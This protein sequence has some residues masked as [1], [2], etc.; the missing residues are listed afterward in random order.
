MQP[1]PFLEAIYQHYAAYKQANNGRPTPLRDL[2]DLV[3]T[4]PPPLCAIEKELKRMQATIRMNAAYF[5]AGVGDDKAPKWCEKV[6]DEAS[7]GDDKAANVGEKVED[8]AA[9]EDTEDDPYYVPNYFD[10]SEA[11]EEEEQAKKK[12]QIKLEHDTPLIYYTDPWDGLPLGYVWILPSSNE[13]MVQ[14]EGLVRDVQ[15]SEIWLGYGETVCV[16][17]G[18]G[19][20]FFTPQMRKRDIVSETPRKKKKTVSFASETRG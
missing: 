11:V 17:G 4:L 18:S 6:A 15:D 12:E 20:A 13:P 7:V 5:N 10:L 19:M 9:G 2:E 3:I 14:N 1:N 8:E 16:D